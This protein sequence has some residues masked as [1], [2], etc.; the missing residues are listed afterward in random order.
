M[1]CTV[2]AS[3][4]SV[5]KHERVLSNQEIAET[6]TVSYGS[7]IRLLILTGQRRGK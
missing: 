5:A 2:V 6:W 1:A 3:N 4:R 7:I